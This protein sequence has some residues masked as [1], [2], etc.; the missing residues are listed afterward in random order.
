MI[1]N[2][3]IR[4]VRDEIDARV[5]L[6][7]HGREVRRYSDA[8]YSMSPRSRAKIRCLADYAIRLHDARY[9]DFV[10]FTIFKLLFINLV[11]P[12]VIDLAKGAIA[13]GIASSVKQKMIDPILD[14]LIGYGKQLV[15]KRESDTY[16]DAIT[17]NIKK[18]FGLL[19]NTLK[20]EG[21]AVSNKASF[22]LN[23]MKSIV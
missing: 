19:T 3:I 22:L 20:R 2:R 13:S 6:A 23:K 14:R 5:Y 15:T 21:S 17:R 12:F 18:D 7:L 9:N 10:G 4:L 1:T 16:T 8:Y 11:L